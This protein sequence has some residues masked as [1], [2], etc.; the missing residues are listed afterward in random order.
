MERNAARAHPISFFYRILFDRC[1]IGPAAAVVALCAAP[2]HGVT[3]SSGIYTT[4]AA[5]LEQPALCAGAPYPAS[6]VWDPA[7]TFN[8]PQSASTGKPRIE[9]YRAGKLI[10]TY[11]SF[12]NQA[13][14]TYLGGGQDVQNPGP[15]AAS[16]CGP[17]T[18]KWAFRLAL[19]GDHFLVYPAVY[20]GD[21]NQPWFGPMWDSYEDFLAGITHDPDGIT[22]SG[23]VVGNRRPVIYLNDYAADNTLGQAPVYFA[24]GTGMVW[25][26]IN[27]IAGP[28]A[29]VGKAG[30][31]ID[32]ANN[33]TINDSR[34]SGFQASYANGI[35]T[36]GQSAGY[37]ALNRDEIDHNGGP[38]GPAHNV[39]VAGS[40]VDPA[41]TVYLTNSWS[42]NAYYGHAF[43]SRA[44]VNVL[45][46]NY[47]DSESQYAEA[48]DLGESYVVDI[49]NGGL[50]TMRNNILHKERSGYGTNGTTMAFGLEGFI[51]SRPQGVDIENNTWIAWDRTFDGTHAI[52][53]M[54]FLWPPTNPS[55]PAWPANVAARVL[56]NAYVGFCAPPYLGNAAAVLAFSETGLSF[57][58]STR[59]FANEARL[60]TLYPG[61]VPE[62][63]TATYQHEAHPG[64]PRAT[65]IIGARD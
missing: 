59:I 58:F 15:A 42:H 29:V 36:T 24:T 11:K 45:T 19:P 10:A 25:E 38:N 63:G 52:I 64:A 62:I 3:L 40:R 33:L 28:A 23:V 43:K 9:Q 26:N 12:A 8:A 2:A 53:P 54:A 56:K 27:I 57:R 16:G 65:S 48:H 47:L 35:I 55:D 22:I 5:A 20:S 30:I 49:P 6:W 4:Q 7:H 14:C 31:Y 1:R 61:Y 13:S 18:R 21:I 17:F 37:L 50:L 41:Y 60:A 32:A 46:A 44:Q 34:I 39:Y 51:D